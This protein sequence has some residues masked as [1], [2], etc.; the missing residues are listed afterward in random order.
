M[1]K[2]IYYIFVF[3][4]LSFN[5][6]AQKNEVRLFKAEKL[7]IIQ[8]KNYS[9]PDFNYSNMAA[10]VNLGAI[11]RETYIDD[12]DISILKD[13]SKYYPLTDA[14]FPDNSLKQIVLLANPHYALAVTKNGTRIPVITDDTGNIFSFRIENFHLEYKTKRTEDVNGNLKIFLDVCSI[15]KIK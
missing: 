8:K 9:N 11:F 6:F 10:A 15:A 2:A 14:K 7:K 4:F 13:L 1:K 12:A 5:S 3:L